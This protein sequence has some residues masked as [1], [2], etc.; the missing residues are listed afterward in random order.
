[1]ARIWAVT[2]SA[3]PARRAPCS[4]TRQTAARSNGSRPSRRAMA[5][6]EPRVLGGRLVVAHEL[7]VEVG[8][9]LEQLVE[10]GVACASR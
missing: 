7:V 4:T 8:G 3:S 2:R 5:A 6:I 10:V 9:D 1:M